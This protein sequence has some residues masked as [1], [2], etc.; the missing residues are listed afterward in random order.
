MRRIVHALILIAAYS[1]YVRLGQDAVEQRLGPGPGKGV[2]ALVVFGLILGVG[3]FI[4]GKLRPRDVGWRA[5]RVARDVG[6]G[7]VGAAVLAVGLIA[8]LVVFRG[9]S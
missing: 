1:A 6:L 8:I 3:L 7:V 5:D 9:A 2:G 4:V